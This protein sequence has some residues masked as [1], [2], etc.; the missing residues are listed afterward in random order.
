VLEN[1]AYAYGWPSF[2]LDLTEEPPANPTTKQKLHIRNAYLVIINKTHGHVVANGLKLVERGDARAAFKR[3]HDF[4]QPDS[5]AGKNAAFRQFYRASMKTTN[6]NIMQWVAE[7][8]LRS[9]I[10]IEAGGQANETA[11]LSVLMDGL[12]PEFREMKTILEHDKSVTFQ[13]ACDSLIEHA[14]SRK[15]E[16]LTK[17]GA[18]LNGKAN[19]FFNHQVVNQATQVGNQAA[20]DS[21]APECRLWKRGLCGY[22]DRCKFQHNGAGGTVQRKPRAIAK[23]AKPR[24]VPSPPT[25]PTVPTT[26]EAYMVGTDTPIVEKC[27]NCSGS[28][29]MKDCPTAKVFTLDSKRNVNYVFMMDDGNEVD[30]S[31]CISAAVR[32][33]LRRPSGGSPP[34]ASDLSQ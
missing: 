34:P 10:L 24:D 1:Q 29:A 20:P 3:V 15:I 23:Y 21:N 16:C 2:I 31:S 32:R 27:E 7:V 19:S 30:D 9:R 25:P 28:H 26:P 22:G 5:Q 6:T 14:R 17:D 4:F 11:Q 13:S 33:T 18:K 12:L 8:H